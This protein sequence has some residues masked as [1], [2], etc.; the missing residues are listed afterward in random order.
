P[1]DGG[2][3]LGIHVAHGGLG[4]SL[5]R[6]ARDL[7]ALRDRQRL[8]VDDEGKEAMNGSEPTVSCA[9]G[10]L[11]LLLQIL[12][13]R[14]HLTGLQVRERQIHDLPSHALGGKLQ[15]QLPGVAIRTYGVTREI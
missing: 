11:P 10:H 14:E 2:D 3:L 5:D 4:P 15:E 8:A 7:R 6:D 13:E 12:E 9:D 1:Q